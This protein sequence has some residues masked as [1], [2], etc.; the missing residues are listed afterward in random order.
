MKYIVWQGRY[1]VF[2]IDNLF[3]AFIGVSY[4]IW[5][6]FESTFRDRFCLCVCNTIFKWIPG[7][8]FYLQYLM[9]CRYQWIR[10]NEL[11]KLMR[12]F[13]SNFKFVSKLMAENRKIL[14]RISSLKYWSKYNTLHVNGF[15]SSSSTNYRKVFFQTLNSVYLSV[16]TAIFKR[17]PGLC[18]GFIRNP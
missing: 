6:V 8:C 10:L 2:L 18:C 5:K 1:I 11:C 7:L 16:Y 17:I 13:S 3:S 4:I 15:F 12:S 9:L 14:K